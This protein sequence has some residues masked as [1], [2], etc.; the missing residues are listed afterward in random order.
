MKS[1]LTALCCSLALTSVSAEE[2]TVAAAELAPHA[3]Q[4]VP[5]KGWVPRLLSYALAERGYK[6]NVVFMPFRRALS[7]AQQGKVHA[8]APLYKSPAREQLMI[9]SEPLAYSQTAI[10]YHHQKPIAFEQVANLA[11]L[12][13]AV[14]RGARVSDEFDRASEIIKVEVSSYEQLVRML[15][16]RRVDGLVGEEF[17][18][19]NAMLT[20]GISEQV[21]VQADQPLAT[22]GLYAAVSKQLPNAIALVEAINEGVN[23][24]RDSGALREILAEY[25]MQEEAGTL[26]MKQ[27]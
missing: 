16:A 8:M 11:R 20:A 15:V 4:Q 12:K 21:L 18:V 24:A 22:Q 3:G 26:R 5:N 17:V 10:F 25:A 13:I 23:A 2:L 19:R 1:W 27:D 14:M 9:F 7:S 6:T